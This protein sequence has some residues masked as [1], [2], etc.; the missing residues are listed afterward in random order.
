MLEVP[1]VRDMG[2]G[3]SL[4]ELNRRN[5]PKKAVQPV[6]RAPQPA[7][8]NSF[9]E[10]GGILNQFEREYFRPL[11]Q[12]TSSLLMLFLQNLFIGILGISLLTFFLFVS[13]ETFQVNRGSFYFWA[14]V[15]MVPFMI[16]IGGASDHNWKILGLIVLIIGWLYFAGKFVFNIWIY[17]Y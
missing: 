9:R 7:A 6:R 10:L 16:I 1:L 17:N 5:R 3:I 12:Q 11:G 8:W 4:E 15:F 14:Y 13:W 2:K